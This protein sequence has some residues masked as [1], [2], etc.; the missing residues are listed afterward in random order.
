MKRGYIII[1]SLLVLS[2]SVNAQWLWNIDKLNQ[3]KGDIHS[4][5][6]AKAYNDLLKDANRLL[7]A[8]P[9][10][11]VNKEGIAPSGDKH[12]YV[13]LSR[14]VWPDPSKKDGLPYIHRDGESNPELEKY[15]R[16]PLGS[17]AYAVNTLS[18]A[19]F[20]TGDERYAAKATDFIRTWFL[21]KDTKMNPN[22]E[23]AQFI[24]GVNNSKGRSAGLIDTYSF[25]DMLNSIKLL[26]GSKSYTTKDD[27][28]LKKWFSDFSIWWQTSEQ[29]IGENN[30]KNNHGLAYDVQ[31]VMF[32]LFSGDTDGARKVINEYPEK[33]LFKQVEPDGSQPH[34][35]RRTLAYHYSLYN[36]AHMI[37]MA[38]IAKS[39]GIDLIKV[40]SGDGRNFYKA[41]DFITPY[42]GKDISAWPYQ[43]ISG[44]NE[45]QQD[46][47]D[48]LLRIVDI[49]PTQTDYLEL[50][51]TYDKRGFSNRNRL[52]YGAP[53]TID[54]VFSF[55]SNQFDF[56]FACIDKAFA[57]KKDD[58][59][60]NPRTVEKDGSL[61]LVRSKDWCSGFFPGSL[62]YMYDY[63]KDNKWKVKAD[64]HSRM[65]ENEQFDRTTH[66]LGFKMYCSFGNGYRLTNDKSY[67]A[68]VIQSA[69]T[70]IKR[71]N[72]KV[73]SIRSWDHN[74]DKWQFPV[75]VDNMLNLE[76]LFEA[77]K[78]TGDPVFYQIAETHAKTTLKNHFRPDYSSYHVVD[79][80]TLTGKVVAKHTHQGYAHESSW[81]RGQGW[82]IYGFTMSYRYTK[83]PDFLAQ[84]EK[85]ANF[86]FTNPN[87]PE[88]MIPYWDFDAPGIPNEPRD[89][90]AACVIASALYE[91]SGYSSQ[92][93]IKYMAWADNIMSNLIQN[94]MAKEGTEQGFLLLHSTGNYPKS[95]EIDAPISYAD[96]YFL[97]ALLRRKAL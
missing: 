20:Y 1:L 48:N 41:M 12:D 96:Y 88:D 9:Y 7:T 23:Y 95:D 61:R 4:L 37:D 40:E 47:C 87:L 3:I 33:R 97:E 21:D 38:A 65:I 43:Q 93:K 10:S 5:T 58:R 52:Y 91:L 63:S 55:A 66:D 89:A 26:S 15:D 13:S 94:Y 81:A 84:A 54:E 70:L 73:G 39:L 50:F 72:E 74:R 16:N 25:V 78:I 18:L 82:G 29:G 64:K 57:E 83:N 62:W 2:F 80:D 69:K 59:L 67:E 90:S 68:V 76:L 51:K 36:I 86:I 28:E 56:A 71:F 77:S 19:Y 34:E 49:D 45:K 22:L 75:I 85:I 35:L 46:V 31:L 60:T 24:P 6:Y 32:L 42:L 11:V 14:Y 79:Y 27:T 30:A 17:M 44:W 8:K 92:N 53:N